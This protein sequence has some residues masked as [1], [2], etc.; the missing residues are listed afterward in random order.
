MRND[1]HYGGDS[2]FKGIDDARWL[3]YVRPV[4]P[5]NDATFGISDTNINAVCNE[6]ESDCQ[7]KPISPEILT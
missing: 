3:A 2:F 6:A 5:G 1:N 7:S 4:K